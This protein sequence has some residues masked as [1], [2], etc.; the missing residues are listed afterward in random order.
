MGD[1]KAY[2]ELVKKILEYC[3]TGE[4]SP[5]QVRKQVPT[6]NGKRIRDFIIDNRS[7]KMEFWQ[8]LKRI[9]GVEKILFDAK[10]YKDPVEYAQI[11]STLRYL[12]TK[13][14]GN[15]II[16]ISRCGVKDYEE[17]LEDYLAEE[18]VVLF[19]GDADLVKMI[20][21]KKEGESPTLLIEEKYHALLD[22]R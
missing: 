21:L 22:M 15:F 9:R 7:P 3:F 17:L 5:F 13:A 20:N 12:K 14:F 11:S 6:N 18:R 4:F 10:N 19:L 8:S 1:G 16:I 2:E